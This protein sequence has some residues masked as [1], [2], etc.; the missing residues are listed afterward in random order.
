MTLVW[1]ILLFASSSSGF[2]ANHS[3]A[4]TSFKVK[5]V[6]RHVPSTTTPT[7]L[8]NLTQSDFLPRGSSSTTHPP[9]LYRDRIVY[10]YSVVVVFIL[11]SAFV[12]CYKR[13]RMK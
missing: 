12:E 8:V 3:V 9:R 10:L 6:S 2:V 1:L 11:A 5:H 4:N 7:A 13:Y